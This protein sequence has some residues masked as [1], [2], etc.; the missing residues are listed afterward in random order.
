MG[1]AKRVPSIPNLSPAWALATDRFVAVNIKIASG[2][3]ILL[4]AM[5]IFYGERERELSGIIF[6]IVLVVFLFL[7]SFFAWIIC[8]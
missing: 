8:C 2:R 5:I 1:G 7:L 3:K 4:L 6:Y